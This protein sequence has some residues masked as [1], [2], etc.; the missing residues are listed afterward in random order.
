M[1]VSRRKNPPTRGPWVLLHTTRE[2]FLRAPRR[3]FSF[4]VLRSSE[5]VADESDEKPRKTVSLSLSPLFASLRTSFATHAQGYKELNLIYYFTAGEKEVRCWTLYSG[6]LAPQAAGVI[7][8]DFERGF[9]K[10]EVVAYDDFKSLA[11]GK[12]M[13]EVKAA[14]KYRQEGKT[15]VVKDGDIIHFQFNVTAQKKK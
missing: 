3:R 15:Y 1:P 6:S 2:H 11:T 8:S 13:A 10:A 5:L 14:G 9:I 7:H 12:S 4:F